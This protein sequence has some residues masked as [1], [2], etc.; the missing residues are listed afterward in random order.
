MY[1]T[2]NDDRGGWSITK[3]KLRNETVHE[4][5]EDILHDKFMILYS[6]IF[7]KDGFT[8]NDHFI[9]QFRS[10]VPDIYRYDNEIME[11]RN[12]PKLWHTIWNVGISRD[13]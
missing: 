5:T 7:T 12:T 4:I 3:I 13:K 9:T 10:P 1:K 6:D 11:Q 2:E 8:G